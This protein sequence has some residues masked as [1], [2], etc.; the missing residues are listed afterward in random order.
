M[1]F[2]GEIACLIKMAKN[3]HITKS[4]LG[5]ITCKGTPNGIIQYAEIFL[6]FFLKFE[7]S[8]VVIEIEWHI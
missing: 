1:A 5:S 6:S 3:M 8:W 7:K 4:K 2:I